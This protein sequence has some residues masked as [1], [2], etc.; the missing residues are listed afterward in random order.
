MPKH[1]LLLIPT[2][3]WTCLV[4]ALRTLGSTAKNLESSGATFL[5]LCTNT[6][7]KVAAEIQANAKIPLLHL[8]EPTAQLVKAAGIQKIGSLGKRFT[9]STIVLKTL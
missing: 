9:I 5:V 3:F 4:S 6:M 7:H 1:T 2:R 8:A